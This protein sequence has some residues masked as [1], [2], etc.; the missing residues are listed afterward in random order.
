MRPPLSQIF[1]NHSEELQTM[2]FEVELII[3]D[4][5]LIHVYPNTVET[6]LTT[7]YLLFGRQL[8]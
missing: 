8:A 1:C 3:N 4:V 7:I 5:T 6:C 2:L